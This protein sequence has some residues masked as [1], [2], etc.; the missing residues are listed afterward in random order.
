MSGL[1]GEGGAAVRV[2]SPG[3]SGRTQLWQKCEE[4]DSLEIQGETRSF[5]K[6]LDDIYLQGS[7]GSLDGAD[8]G[9]RAA[10]LNSA[11]VY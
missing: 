5:E 9:A 7:V 11:R 1:K 3:L 8:S 6:G 10:A 2:S 4:P